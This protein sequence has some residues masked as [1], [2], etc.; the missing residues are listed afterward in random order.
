MFLCLKNIVPLYPLNLN[1][2]EDEDTNRMSM[3]VAGDGRDGSGTAA[4]GTISERG[5][6]GRGCWLDG[7]GRDL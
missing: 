5:D 1:A 3:V 6:D 7:V 4:L 2:K